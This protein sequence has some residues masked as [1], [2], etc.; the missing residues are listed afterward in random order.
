MPDDDPLVTVLLAI[1]R[2]I[3]IFIH[4]FR[5]VGSPYVH[6]DTLK[7]IEERLND[8][9]SVEILNWAGQI[10]DRRGPVFAKQIREVPHIDNTI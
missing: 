2:P 4:P 9:Q 10:V 6:F 3:A 1:A 5:V 7:K 8:G